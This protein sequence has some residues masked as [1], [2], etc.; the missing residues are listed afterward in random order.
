MERAEKEA[1]EAAKHSGEKE[2]AKEEVTEIRETFKAKR[3]N[4][5]RRAVLVAPSN[6]DTNP[7]TMSSNVFMK[8]S[9]AL[10]EKLSKKSGRREMR[11]A[12]RVFS[13]A[14][15]SPRLSH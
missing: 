15:P 6:F 9:L 8:N 13:L 2:R 11:E 10:A 14:H 4:S 7:Q 3:I 1:A 5:S 12:V